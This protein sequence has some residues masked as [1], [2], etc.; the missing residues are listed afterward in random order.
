MANRLCSTQHCIFSKALLVVRFGGDCAIRHESGC[1]RKSEAQ[2]TNGPRMTDIGRIECWGAGAPF[3]ACSLELWLS[4]PFQA[5]SMRPGF[6]SKGHS[7]LDRALTRYMT[8]PAISKIS[9]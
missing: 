3:L 9:A 8:I 5:L 2:I 7:F 4:A 1:C 6:R